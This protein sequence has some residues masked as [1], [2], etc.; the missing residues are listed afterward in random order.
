MAVILVEGE[1]QL[2]A[3]IRQGNNNSDPTRPSTSGTAPSYILNF[4]GSFIALGT[5]LNAL[6]V[7]S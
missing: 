3:L 4:S 2:D 7:F 6:A 5:M 1:D